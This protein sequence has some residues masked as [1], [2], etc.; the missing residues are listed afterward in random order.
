VVLHASGVELN[1]RAALFLGSSGAGK[2]TL[3][4]ALVQRGY[5]LVTDDFCVIN[6]G[7]GTVFKLAP[8][9]EETVV[10]RFRGAG[11]GDYPVGGLIEDA[12]G[13]LYGT[14]MYGGTK[15]SNEFCGGGCG[16]VFEVAPDGTETVL[17]RFTGQ[18]DGGYPA[19]GLVADSEGNLYGTTQGGGN[20]QARYGTIFEVTP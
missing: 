8:D 17:Y 6:S 20:V 3:A 18:S 7:C 4:A 1:G 2:S 5:P 13:N 19:A 9:G 16:T 11:S 14:T 10:F 15:E 12:A